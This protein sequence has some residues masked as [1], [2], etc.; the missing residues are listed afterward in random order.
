MKVEIAEQLIPNI[1]DWSHGDIKDLELLSKDEVENWL[2]EFS[3]DTGN[4]S[5][6]DCI[7]ICV[8]ALYYMNKCQKVFMKQ[9]DLK[10]RN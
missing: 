6:W 4:Y 9:N 7:Q 3:D 5:N 8:T 1:N 10:E 2:K